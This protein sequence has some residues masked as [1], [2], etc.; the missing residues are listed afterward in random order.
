MLDEQ[1]IRMVSFFTDTD[2]GFLLFLFTR[3]RNEDL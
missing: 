3:P 1:E 2:G